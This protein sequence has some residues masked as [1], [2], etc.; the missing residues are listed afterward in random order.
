MAAVSSYLTES[1]SG[2]IPDVQYTTKDGG[3]RQRKKSS[4]GQSESINIYQCSLGNNSSAEDN[5]RSMLARDLS[6]EDSIPAHTVNRR[7][8]ALPLADRGISNAS[9][10]FSF[11]ESE[12]QLPDD[13]LP[14]F[15]LL[16]RPYRVYYEPIP[17]HIL[18]RAGMSLSPPSYPL[19]IPGAPLE[20]EQRLPIYHDPLVDLRR[21]TFFP[22][23]RPWGLPP[24]DQPLP[25]APETGALAKLQEPP[26]LAT[27]GLQARC[28]EGPK[29][30][31]AGEK[32]RTI[33]RYRIL[34]HHGREIL[35]YI[36]LKD[37][38]GR[39]VA[40]V[41]EEI[42]TLY[43]K[44]LSP[45]I[46]GTRDP[47]SPGRHRMYTAPAH[48]MTIQAS[49]NRN[50]TDVL[51]HK[52]RRRRSPRLRLVASGKPRCRDEEAAYDDPFYRLHPWGIEPLCACCELVPATC[53]D[54]LHC[55]CSC[56]DT[57][58]VPSVTLHELFDTTRQDTATGF[59]VPGP[60]LG[61]RH[62]PPRGV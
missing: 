7:K 28:V 34:D 40:S 62:P 14:P 39:G 25:E 2:E 50:E 30:L 19:P 15:S 23:H 12:G 46:P 3:Q 61:V 20:E 11:Y 18:T 33:K 35:L 54:R 24:L 49:V 60:V 45:Y 52:A 41:G 38:I 17:E 48:V 27:P 1:A 47:P 55:C 9:S 8:F 58:C 51:Y 10:S 13:P 37:G 53:V 21:E 22:S 43:R 44:R 26:A 16:E 31:P 6:G 32:G 57:C 4:I 59:I 5:S 36:N 29:E 56:C 42:E